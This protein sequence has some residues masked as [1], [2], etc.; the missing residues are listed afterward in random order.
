MP[1]TRLSNIDQFRYICGNVSPDMNIKV[2]A[3]DINVNT[4]SAFLQCDGYTKIYTQWY[5]SHSG[6]IIKQGGGNDT[7]NYHE[8]E[9]QY[10]SAYKEPVICYTTPNINN[11][12]E[13]F[14]KEYEIV[15]IVG[16]VQNT[17]C[18]IHLFCDENQVEELMTR[19]TNDIDMTELTYTQKAQRVCKTFIGLPIGYVIG[20]ALHMLSCSILCI[21]GNWSANYY[22]GVE[23]FSYR[24]GLNMNKRLIVLTKQIWNN[25]KICCDKLLYSHNTSDINYDVLY[26]NDDNRKYV[27]KKVEDMELLI[28]FDKYTNNVKEIQYELLKS[29]YPE[30]EQL[31]NNEL[32]RIQNIKFVLRPEDIEK[33][34]VTTQSNTTYENIQEHEEEEHEEEVE[35]EQVEQVEEEQE[36]QVEEE[37]E[38]VE[39]EQV[40]L[41]LEIPVSV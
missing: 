3:C 36:E 28:R 7:A 22:Q 12:D 4:K 35:Q 33:Y 37:Q 17:I 10:N 2:R 27:L 13:L 16:K 18:K 21:S 41:E 30:D 19:I 23:L 24:T 11:I 29:I 31:R 26:K 40:E 14:E 25:N 39:Q 9:G 8:V 5:M 1:I 32:T 15:K 38:Q 6:Y 34:D 20:T